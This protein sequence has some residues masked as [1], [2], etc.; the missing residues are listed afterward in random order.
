[1]QDLLSR[2]C[3]CPS[4]PLCSSRARYEVHFM[5]DTIAEQVQEA[6]NSSRFEQ[7]AGILDKAELEVG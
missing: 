6:L 2:T 5:S 7:I 3:N 4:F 1:M